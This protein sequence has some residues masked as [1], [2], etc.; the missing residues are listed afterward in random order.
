MKIAVYG[1]SFNPLHIGHY[2][3]IRHLVEVEGFDLVYLVVS[4]KN[5]LK[6]GISAESA[7]QRFEA[8][9]RAVLRRGL[10]DK[11]IVDDIEL[12]MPAPHFTIRTLDALRKR[13]PQNDFTIIMGSDQIADIHRWKD[14][15]RLLCEYGV[16][17]YPRNGFNLEGIIDELKKEHPSCRLGM[18]DAPM[19]DI[20]STAIR[21]AL[22][23][24]R[25]VDDYLM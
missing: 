17:V 2:A 12:K 8:A 15:E 14:Y 6:E 1:G 4:P 22:A 3:I 13:E 19:V 5:P 21:E 7:P 25:S 18:M 10:Q 24:G 11:V 16:L 23:N 20:S 9:R